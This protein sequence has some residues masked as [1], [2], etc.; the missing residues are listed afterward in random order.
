MNIER[1]LDGTIET[2]LE[3]GV[4][5][6][7]HTPL[8]KGLATS[9]CEGT[10]IPDMQTSTLDVTLWRLLVDAESVGRRSSSR[11]GRWEAEK[12]QSLSRMFRTMTTVAQNKDS[13]T[14]TQA[15][16]DLSSRVFITRQHCPFS[17]LHTVDSTTT[18]H[19]AT[20]Q[21]EPWSACRNWLVFRAVWISLSLFVCLAFNG[22]WLFDT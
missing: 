10:N 14:E 19:L 16:S 12:L 4:A 5:P 7:A 21:S 18:P 8:A 3:L 6:I 17:L 22:R 11:M 15:R 9:R 13:R 1:E 2:C 20:L